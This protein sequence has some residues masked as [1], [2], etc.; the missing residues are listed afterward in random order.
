MVAAAAV[1][2]LVA[3]GTAAR[4]DDHSAGSRTCSGL[5]WPEE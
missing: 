4:P 5:E 3:V 1:V 2:V